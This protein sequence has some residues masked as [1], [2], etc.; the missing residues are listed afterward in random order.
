MM[1][2]M[3]TT[4]AATTAATTQA[5]ATAAAAAQTAQQQ[6]CEIQRVQRQ[7]SDTRLPLG[8]VGQLVRAS[9]C[10]P[11]PEKETTPTRVEFIAVGR[12]C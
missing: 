2:L 10:P 11:A 6:M 9:A 3:R 7:M 8:A 12:R 4:L 5:A 1:E